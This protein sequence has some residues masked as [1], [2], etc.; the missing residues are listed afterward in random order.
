[1]LALADTKLALDEQVSAQAAVSGELAGNIDIDEGS[2]GII[3]KKVKTSLMSTLQ[4]RFD[5]GEIDVPEIEEGEANT[6][7]NVKAED[8][9]MEGEDT[10]TAGD[11]ST[12]E[13][14][15]ETEAA[16]PAPAPAPAKTGGRMKFKLAPKR[17]KP[18]L[19]DDGEEIKDEN[20]DGEDD[21]DDDA[22]SSVASDGSE[23]AGE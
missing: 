17:E 11:A 12:S 5:G 21:E 19:D 18:K 23:Y 14:T 6:T 8:V 22:L 10:V 2:E 4:R 7:A 3:E 13:A 20:G 1:M 16:A 15:K 9:K